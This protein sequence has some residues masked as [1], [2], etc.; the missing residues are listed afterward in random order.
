[1]IENSI[2][3]HAIERVGNVIF[4]TVEQEDMDQVRESHILANGCWPGSIK[5]S[6]NPHCSISV[7]TVCLDVS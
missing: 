7:G 6:C 3:R 5:V 2:I 4:A 1:M